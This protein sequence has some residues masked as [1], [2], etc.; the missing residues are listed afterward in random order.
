MLLSIQT[1]TVTC[2]KLQP[3]L[4]FRI[5]E[6]T[7]GLKGSYLFNV[8]HMNKLDCS[9]TLKKKK[10]KEQQRFYQKW[11]LITDIPIIQSEVL[12]FQHPLVC[13]LLMAVTQQLIW[14]VCYWGTWWKDLSII[15]GTLTERCYLFTH[16]KSVF[17]YGSKWHWFIPRSHTLFYTF[18]LFLPFWKYAK[19]KTH[20]DPCKTHVRKSVENSET[21]PKCHTCIQNSSVIQL[22]MTNLP[23]IQIHVMPI[24]W[25]HRSTEWCSPSVFK[26]QQNV[27][28]AQCPDNAYSP[29]TA[30]VSFNS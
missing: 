6:G 25:V 17:F 23:E 19:T 16:Y 2:W 12:D 8:F 18:C 1:V 10:K 20:F 7:N 22:I 4:A 15:V 13:L 24:W 9:F 3:C 5:G 11:M 26:E 14:K 30:A 27:F 29:F 21:V 28:A